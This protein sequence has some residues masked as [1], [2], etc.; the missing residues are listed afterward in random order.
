ME[1]RSSE[2]IRFAL[3]RGREGGE[4]Q[5]EDEQE[6]PTENEEQGGEVGEKRD[7]E[8]FHRGKNDRGVQ[9]P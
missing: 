7:E 3:A 2:M 4:D 9:L 8:L 6:G 5:N 1:P